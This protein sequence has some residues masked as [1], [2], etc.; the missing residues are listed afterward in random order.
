MSK[1]Q[2]LGHVCVTRLCSFSSITMSTRGLMP[3]DCATRAMI[4]AADSFAA[5][6]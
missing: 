2:L 5:P 1:R 3:Q 6:L 4:V